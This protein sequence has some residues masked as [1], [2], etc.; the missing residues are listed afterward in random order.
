MAEAKLVQV[1]VT[2]GVVGSG[3]ETNPSRKQW[4]LWTIDGKLICRA[5]SEDFP[6]DSQIA[7]S[8]LAALAN[9]SSGVVVADNGAGG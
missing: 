1:I 4:E 9:T 3:D 2:S 8:N 7:P 5:S 6:Q